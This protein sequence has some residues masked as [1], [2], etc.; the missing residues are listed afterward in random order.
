MMNILYC[1]DAHMQKGLFLS[2]LSLVKHCSEPLTIYVLTAKI[3]T[4]EK[5]Y[6]PL[7]DCDIE[8]LDRYVKGKNENSQVLKF[9]I[10]DL[11]ANNMLTANWKTSFTPNCML[12]LYADQVASLPDKLLYLDTDII[13]YNHFSDFYQ[14]DL[15]DY[16]VCGVLDHYGKWFFHRQLQTFD[17]LN[18]GVLLMNLR[19]IRETDLFGRCRKLCKERW[20]FMPDQSAINRLS[21]AKKIAPSRFNE[22]HALK[23]ETVFLHFTTR[24]KFFP[25]FQIVNVKPWQI[26]RVHDELQLFDYDDLFLTYQ[27]IT[28]ESLYEGETL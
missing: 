8:R 17:Y 10:T 2:V 14:Q 25:W 7:A 23:E 3:T 9:D 13:C 12:R 11:V 22:Q 27:E 4:A 24:F 21:K 16:D 6:E 20:M 18:S 26:E 5:E 19:R 28:N 1:G 15:T